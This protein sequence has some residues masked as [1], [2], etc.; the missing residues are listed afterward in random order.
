[1]AISDLHEESLIRV[2]DRRIQW[3]GLVVM[4]ACASVPLYFAD[5]AKAGYFPRCPIHSFTGLYCPGCG[6]TRAMH[7]LLHGN[8][9]AAMRLNPLALLLLPVLVYS[10][11]SF[12][13]EVFRGKALPRLFRT[14]K[15]TWLL[16]AAVIAFTVLRNIPA[17]PFTLLAPGKPTR[18]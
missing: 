5:P 9:G 13:L 18:R 16:I 17:Y 2:P 4:C 6:T 11:L 8:P 14:R 3:L 15:S 12:T 1:M 7:Q 10:F